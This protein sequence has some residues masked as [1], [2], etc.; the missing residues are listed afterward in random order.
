MTEPAT[1][2]QD[3]GDGLPVVHPDAC[4]ATEL[5]PGV[6]VRAVVGPRRGSPLTLDHVQFATGARWRFPPEHGG[7]GRHLLVSVLDGACTL[8]R[9]GEPPVALR[10]GS[11]VLREP[12]D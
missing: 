9:D 11:A 12:D 7:G 6:A 5:A 8:N 3:L 4:R 1:G 2:S 10:A